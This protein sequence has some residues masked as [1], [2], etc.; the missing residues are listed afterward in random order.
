MNNR[1]FSSTKNSGL[2]GTLRQSKRLYSRLAEAESA[3][4]LTVGI[5]KGN[6]IAATT[7][8]SLIVVIVQEYQGIY[9]VDHTPVF[10]EI[11]Q[12]L[13]TVKQFIDFSTKNTSPFRF[14]VI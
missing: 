2:K 5:C 12:V 11:R 9:P 8:V 1:D 10:A 6:D 3:R 7:V 13:K 14:V 4:P